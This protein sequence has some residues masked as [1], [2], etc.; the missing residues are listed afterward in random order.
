MINILVVDDSGVIRLQVKQILKETNCR[1]FEAVNG[2]Q[3]ILN[4]FS[5]DYSLKDMDL[6]LLDIHLG[7]I[8]GYEVLKNITTSYPSLP[9][10]MMSIERRKENILKCINLGAKDYILKPFN[11][12]ML[13][14]RINRFHNILFR[15]QAEE[16]D[17]EALDN[18]L[19]VEIDRA[20]RV[21]VPLTV[22]ILKVNSKKNTGRENIIYKKNLLKIL[23][24]IDSVLTY[25]KYIVLI[26]PLANKDNFE[27]VKNKISK[28]F[29]EVGITYEEEISQKVFFYPDDVKEKELIQNF[30]SKAIKDLI[31]A[32]CLVPQN[33]DKK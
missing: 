22:L 8:D 13:I 25:N 26:L 10:I 19:L 30:N 17:I 1:I 21:N 15:K 14:S 32:G 7:E 23:R 33:F 24:K 12:E 31:L 18:T 29:M 3:V 9:V 28:A 16:A 11:K 2:K 5:K 6:V 20:I 27:I 4:T